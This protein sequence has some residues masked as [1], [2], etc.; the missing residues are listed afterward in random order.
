MCDRRTM[1]NGFETLAERPRGSVSR[2]VAVDWDTLAPEEARRLR[3]LG[4]DDGVTVKLAHRGIFSG[5]DP[6]AL[7]IGRMTIAVRR[8]HAEAITVE[9]VADTGAQPATGADAAA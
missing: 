5:R 6:L 9:A 7:E 4:I 2:I 3:A 8:V 1:T